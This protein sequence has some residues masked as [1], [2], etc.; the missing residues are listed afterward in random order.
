MN[1]L[2]SANINNLNLMLIRDLFR[3]H[4]NERRG[5]Q[6]CLFLS[7]KEIKDIRNFKEILAKIMN[8]FKQFSLK[9]P[10]KNHNCFDSLVDFI[11]LASNQ[12]EILCSEIWKLEKFMEYVFKIANDQKRFCSSMRLDSSE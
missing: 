9:H 1:A 4:I 2:F 7:E 5:L 8:Q 12:N 6:D 10:E 11:K 3:Q